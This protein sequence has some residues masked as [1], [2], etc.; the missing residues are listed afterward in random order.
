MVS[1]HTIVVKKAPVETAR[2][3]N[4]N[5]EQTDKRRIMDGCDPM[6]SA[7]TVPSLAHVAGRCVS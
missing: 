5:P 4:K 3:I 1:P 7:V 2:E 6:F